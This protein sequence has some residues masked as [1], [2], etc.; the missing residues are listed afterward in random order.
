MAKL[1]LVQLVY[2]S[3]ES[4]ENFEAGRRDAGFDDAA[5]IGLTLASDERTLFHT[6]KKTSHVRVARNHAIADAFTRKAGRTGTAEDAKDVVLS[7]GKAVLFDESIG[8]LGK[9][10]GGAEKRDE[11]FGFEGD[12]GALSGFRRRTHGREYKRYNDYCQ[13]ENKGSLA[14]FDERAEV[15]FA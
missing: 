2:G 10:V 14:G 7:A 15:D 13:E 6:V 8:I 3:V 4:L 12:G 11:E 5:V 9:E 1:G